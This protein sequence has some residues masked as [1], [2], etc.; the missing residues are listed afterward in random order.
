MARRR[1]ALVSANEG[2]EMKNFNRFR[3]N[4]LTWSS[5]SPTSEFCESFHF[6]F[7]R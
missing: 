6:S 1:E 7:D 5:D 2:K 3:I 4:V